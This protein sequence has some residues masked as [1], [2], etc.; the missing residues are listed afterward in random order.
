MF[1]DA[2][3]TLLRK[4]AELAQGDDRA[5]W[6]AFVDRAVAAIER[7]TLKQKDFSVCPS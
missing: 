5:E 6:E 3:Q 1:P 2:P 7:Q 4:I